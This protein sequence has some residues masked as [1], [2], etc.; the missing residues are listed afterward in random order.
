MKKV[1]QSQMRTVRRYN[2]YLTHLVPNVSPKPS[3]RRPLRS[4]CA[5]GLA[6]LLPEGAALQ[7]GLQGRE[8]LARQRVV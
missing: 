2:V 3:P 8:E 4:Q 7:R 6:A 1:R 5:R